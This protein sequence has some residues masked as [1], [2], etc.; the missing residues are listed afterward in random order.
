MKRRCLLHKNSYNSNPGLKWN[1]RKEHER[2]TS[3]DGR[4]EREKSVLFNS[5]TCGCGSLKYQ[6]DPSRGLMLKAFS[7]N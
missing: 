3:I 5:K 7:F 4:K 1:G 6:E 2:E